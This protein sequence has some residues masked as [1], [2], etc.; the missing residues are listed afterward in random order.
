MTVFIKKRVLINFGRLQWHIQFFYVIKYG[1]KVVKINILCITRESSAYSSIIFKQFSVKDSALYFICTVDVIFFCCKNVSTV[2]T[3]TS[4]SEVVAIHTPHTPHFYSND[5]R[6]V[7]DTQK[8]HIVTSSLFSV[9][10]FS[11][12]LKQFRF[13]FSSKSLH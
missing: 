9:L 8:Q 13:F 11:G 1:L 10:I 2:V 4:I 6:N 3:F 12:G 7:N 5:K